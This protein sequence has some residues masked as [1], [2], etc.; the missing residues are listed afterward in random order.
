MRG[1]SAL[2]VAFSLLC[3]FLDVSC[4]VTASRREKTIP[5]DLRQEPLARNNVSHRVDV[6]CSVAKRGMI[7]AWM[8]LRI[9]CPRSEVDEELDASMVKSS[10]QTRARR[11]ADDCIKVC[12]RV[13]PMNDAEKEGGLGE[14]VAIDRSGGQALGWENN[15]SDNRTYTHAHLCIHTST[16]NM[17]HPPP[18]T[19]A[20]R[21]QHD[22]KL[23]TQCHT[24]MHTTTHTCSGGD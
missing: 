3:T 9:V 8:L 14:C 1:M 24:R 17:R 23:T 4:F 13:R 22:T 21:I 10:S 16:T 2:H 18:P 7:A 5:S 19:T 6:P 15:H 20:Q 11:E 12:V